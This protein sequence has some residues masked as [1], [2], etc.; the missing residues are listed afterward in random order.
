M[1]IIQE[2]LIFAIKKYQKFF[3]PDHGDHTHN[4]IP[5]CNYYPSCSQYSIESI[6]K[7]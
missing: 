1:N 5:Y 3:S 2:K 6:E 7:K 4:H